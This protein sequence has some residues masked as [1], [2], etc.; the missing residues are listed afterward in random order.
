MLALTVVAGGAL[1]WCIELN[2]LEAQAARYLNR[3]TST[4]IKAK[5]R[6]LAWSRSP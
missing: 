6:D 2:L 1:A 4:E 5:R 3:G